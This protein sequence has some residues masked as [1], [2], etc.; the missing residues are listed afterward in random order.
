MEKTKKIS[1]TVFGGGLLSLMG[2]YPN[3]LWYEFLSNKKS[4]FFSMVW[5]ELL[6]RQYTLSYRNNLEIRQSGR[7]SRESGRIAGF[8]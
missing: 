4:I 2:K 6:Y 3:L 1:M 8:M 5:Q 7:I